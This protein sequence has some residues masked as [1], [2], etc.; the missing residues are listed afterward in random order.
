MAVAPMTINYARSGNCAKLN[1]KVFTIP[2][3]NSFDFEN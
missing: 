1:N 2:V 3:T